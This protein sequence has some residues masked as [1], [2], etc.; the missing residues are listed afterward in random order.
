M[1]ESKRP[2]RVGVLGTGIGLRRSG[3]DRRAVLGSV[4]VHIGVVA[5]LLVSGAVF[6]PH[7]P[8]FE[9]YRVQLVSPPPQLAGEP[10]PVR[11]APPVVRRPER[12]VE[13]PRQQQ[14]KPRPVEQKPPPKEEPKREPEPTRGANP[15]PDSPGGEDIQLDMEGKE[16]PFPDYLENIIFVLNRHF[17]WSGNPALEGEV[18]FYIERDGSVGRGSIQ[19][20]RKSGDFR[21]DLEMMSAV[22]QAGNRRAFGALPDG[23]VSDKLWVRFKF[24]P[25][26]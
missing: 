20:T 19:V 16:F 9:V 17:R 25:P 5:V 2:E 10:A 4:L 3:P 12:T 23:W 11:A 24:L 14:P 21:F 7:M 26:S 1:T 22:E 8:A 6:A 18:A 13:T 15:K